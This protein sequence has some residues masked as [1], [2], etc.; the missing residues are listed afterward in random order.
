MEKLVS[1][2]MSFQRLYDFTIGWMHRGNAKDEK[3]IPSILI[4]I[5]TRSIYRKKALVIIIGLTPRLLSEII[6]DRGNRHHL[7]LQL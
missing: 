2:T 3:D 4:I 5:L 7:P 6:T 1:E